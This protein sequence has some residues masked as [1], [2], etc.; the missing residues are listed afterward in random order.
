MNR[1]GF[2][3]SVHYLV[4]RARLFYCFNWMVSNS[5]SF[6]NPHRS[7]EDEGKKLRARYFTP[8][9]N[10]AFCMTLTYCN[11]G[12]SIKQQTSESKPFGKLSNHSASWCLALKKHNPGFK[13]LLHQIKQFTTTAALPT[14][15]HAS[16]AERKTAKSM[17]MFTYW[18]YWNLS[19]HKWGC[20]YQINVWLFQY[21]HQTTI[22]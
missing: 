15:V 12:L 1:I 3:L 22:Q 8:S 6:H 17:R 10:L 19:T 18:F 4:S 20:V 16:L 7:T 2:P 14:F 9:G 21:H 13:D 11:F 5:T